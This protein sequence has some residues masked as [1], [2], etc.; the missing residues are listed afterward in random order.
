M[1]VTKGK[2]VEY[3]QGMGWNEQTT[4]WNLPNVWPN[5]GALP[6]LGLWQRHGAEE[7]ETVGANEDPKRV[8]A[9]V[10][11]HQRWQE[12]NQNVAH[13]RNH[14]AVVAGTWTKWIK[15]TIHTMWWFNIA[16][17]HGSFNDDYHDDLPNLNSDCPV[18]KPLNNKRVQLLNGCSAADVSLL[19]R[20]AIQ[21]HV[22]VQPDGV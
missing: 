10:G 16:M 12:G 21:K 8:E 2:G 4:F 13:L 22:Q 19:C 3:E 11:K 7:A 18:R 1:V 15:H 6:H 9:P 14:I 20:Q 5:L 17:E